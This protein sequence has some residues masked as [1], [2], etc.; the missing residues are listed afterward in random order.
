[1]KKRQSSMKCVRILTNQCII[2]LIHFTVQ[3]KDMILKIGH[4]GQ[5]G[6]TGQGENT[7]RSFQN[8]LTA[9]ADGLE[10]DVRK[11]KDDKLV[12]I[13]DLAVD[14]TTNGKG[15]V[16]ELS[17]A[18]LSKLDAGFGEAIPLL[19]VVLDKFAGKLLLNIELKESGVEEMVKAEILGRGLH[20]LPYDKSTVVSAF[21]QDDN[22]PDADSSWEQLKVFAPEIPIALLAQ[23]SKIQRMGEGEF[24]KKA[25]EYGAIAIH[26]E[27]TG[28]T[29]SLIDLAHQEG[30]MVN[31][32]TANDPQEIQKLKELGVDGFISDFVERL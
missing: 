4:R 11:T 26:P 14:R 27:S 10:F 16:S 8:A 17:Y 15:K 25:K 13:H 6:D 21:D 23:A 3:L 1:M 24:V 29:S 2:Y 19:S 9:G 12:V 32:W 7:I 28:V 31:V 18:D 30:M 22:D 20:K 5:S